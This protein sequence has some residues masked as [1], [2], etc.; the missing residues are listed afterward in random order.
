MI[1]ADHINVKL[2]KALDRPCDNE[3]THDD[4]WDCPDCDGTGR[5]VF[6]LEVQEV[7]PHRY[8]ERAARV[9]LARRREHGDALFMVESDGDWYTG[10]FRTLRVHVLDVLPIVAG[11]CPQTTN[12]RQHSHIHFAGYGTAGICWFDAGLV[13]DSPWHSENR[14]TLPLAA[15][16][17]MWAVRLA[18]HAPENMEEPK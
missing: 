5:H 13:R 16:P 15:V 10:H 3:F 7:E 1:P 12:Q 14:I 2:A 8:T 17:G 18:I 6:E 9:R 4:T 11:A